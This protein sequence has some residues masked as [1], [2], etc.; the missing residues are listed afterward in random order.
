MLIII[1]DMSE[2]FNLAGYK[3]FEKKINLLKLQVK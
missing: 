3:I 1:H 2:V